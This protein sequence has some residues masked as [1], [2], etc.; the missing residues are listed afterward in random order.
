MKKHISIFILSVLTLLV[1][2]CDPVEAGYHVEEPARLIPEDKMTQ[3]L[4]DMHIIEGARSGMRVL[5]DSVPVDVYYRG[6][7]EKYDVTKGQYDSSFRYYSADPDLMMEMYDIV[8]DSIRIMEIQAMEDVKA[9]V[10]TEARERGE[11]SSEN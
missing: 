6:F 8:I 7:Y 4:L 10:P 2:S 3:M 11:Q 9:Y 1:L 5:G